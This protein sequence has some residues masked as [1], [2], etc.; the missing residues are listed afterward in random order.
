MQVGKEEELGTSL[1]GGGGRAIGLYLTFQTLPAVTA[2]IR[3]CV[4]ESEAQNGLC[5]SSQ[6]FFYMPLRS[7]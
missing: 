3:L 4:L 6:E 7:D 1:A 2:H 5:D